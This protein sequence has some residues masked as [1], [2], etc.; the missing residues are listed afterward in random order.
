[1]VHSIEFKFGTYIIGHRPTNCAEPGEF[2]I[3]NFFTGAQKRILK[4]Y[5]LWSQIVRSM[6]VSKPYFRLKSNLI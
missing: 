5:S 4:H 1:M 2:R 6:V 3:Q